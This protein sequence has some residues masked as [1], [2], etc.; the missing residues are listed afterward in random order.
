MEVICVYGVRKIKLVI[1]LKWC[2]WFPSGPM[3]NLSSIST[4][5]VMGNVIF[6]ADG[7]IWLIT[8]SLHGTASLLHL[9]PSFLLSISASQQNAWSFLLSNLFIH[10]HRHINYS[11]TGVTALYPLP[12]NYL[13]DDV[14]E[15]LKVLKACWMCGCYILLYISSVCGFPSVAMETWPHSDPSF[16]NTLLK[17]NFVI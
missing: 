8:V 2:Q 5:G 16:G 15:Y 4:A 14:G 7:L 1:K 10:T 13:S 6:P 12:D 11:L 17:W 3:L 9:S